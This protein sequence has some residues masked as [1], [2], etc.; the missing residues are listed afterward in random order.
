MYDGHNILGNGSRT[1]DGDRFSL[2]LRKYLYC[3]SFSPPNFAAY[4]KVVGGLHFVV[5][6]VSFT[7]RPYLF[8]SNQD[9]AAKPRLS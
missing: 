8:S 4:K 6:A 2:V 7:V 3:V 1:R 9:P 5:S